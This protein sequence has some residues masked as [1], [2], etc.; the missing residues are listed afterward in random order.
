[1]GSG[2]RALPPRMGGMGWVA[3]GELCWSL[4][5][6]NLPGALSGLA[7]SLD[8]MRGC[9]C[10]EL[11]KQAQNRREQGASKAQA[12]RKQG[13][14]KAQKKGAKRAATNASMCQ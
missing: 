14:G 10:D 9:T 8:M 12:R 4:P 1:M 6:R 7:G 5:G 11:Q 3:V 13:A 2:G